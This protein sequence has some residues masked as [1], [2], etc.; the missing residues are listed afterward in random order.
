MG[1]KR[2]EFYDLMLCDF[3]VM[4][5]ALQR[6]RADKWRHTRAI[7]GALTGKDPRFLVPLDG[8]FDHLEITPPKGRVEIAE[9][10]GMKLTDEFKENMLKHG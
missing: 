4:V 3:L 1:L 2:D 9:K 8:D 6:R 5:D 7:L 10:M